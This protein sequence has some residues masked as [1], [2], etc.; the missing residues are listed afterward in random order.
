MVEMGQLGLLQLPQWFALVVD[1]EIHCEV[2]VSRAGEVQ[3]ADDLERSH[4]HQMG[5]Y[6]EVPGGG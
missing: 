2:A 1:K 3:T 4:R 5:T 6:N